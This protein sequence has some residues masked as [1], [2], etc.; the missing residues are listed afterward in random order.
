MQWFRD[1]SLGG[2]N[3]AWMEKKDIKEMT[4]NADETHYV[5]L[6]WFTKMLS[7]G[8]EIKM[9]EP[10]SRL[11]GPQTWYLNFFY[12]V[13]EK[14]AFERNPFRSLIVRMVSVTFGNKIISEVVW[15][16][17]NIFAYSEWQCQLGFQKMYNKSCF[18]KL[19]W[20][21]FCYINLLRKKCAEFLQM[22]KYFCRFFT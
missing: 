4:R 15:Y 8:S 21:L 9:V 19:F 1:E 20:T 2:L 13:V 18:G 16:F 3:V 22:F 14:C 17:A 5:K 12:I 6:L 7:G 10:K 11:F